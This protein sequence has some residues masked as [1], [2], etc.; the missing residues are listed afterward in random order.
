MKILM[1]VISSD[2]HPVYA[3]HREVWRTYQKSHPDV[4][5]VFLQYSPL[6]YAPTRTA[7][8]LFFRGTERYGSILRKT[9]D[10]IAYFLPKAPYTH[11]VRTNLSSVWDFP[12]LIAYLEQQPT[13]RLY[14]G[15]SCGAE[16]IP[17]NYV[18]G[19]GI[20]LSRDVAELLWTHRQR[21]L[22]VGAID[23]VDIGYA[24]QSLGIPQTPAPRVDFLSLDHYTEHREKIPPET[25]HYRVK[26]VNWMGDRLEESEI[27]RRI[28]RDHIYA[29]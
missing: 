14:A 10:A 23:D 9:L 22:S 21:A 16:G 25:F 12:R 8:T 2:T 11:V 4:D 1:L 27:M 17:W 24:M 15:F 18:S 7:D 13:T 26:H 19:A 29:P 3:K 6:V 20:L 28:L 5:V